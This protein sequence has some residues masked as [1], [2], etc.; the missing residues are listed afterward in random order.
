[1]GLRNDT[2]HISVPK[3]LAI[4]F[5]VTLE[6]ILRGMWLVPTRAC[7]LKMHKRGRTT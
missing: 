4:P 1:M 2:E 3:G 5:R 6:W 7:T